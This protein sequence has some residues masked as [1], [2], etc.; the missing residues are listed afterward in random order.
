MKELDLEFRGT[1]EVSNFTFRQIAPSI[2]A[3]VYEIRAAN[4]ERH[5]ETFERK[6]QLKSDAVIAGKCISFDEQVIYPK[7]SS[8]GDWAWCFK[9]KESA[10]RRFE[11]FKKDKLVTAEC[12]LGFNLV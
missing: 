8:F 1:G 10:M 5:Y 3:Y 2:Y 6:E 9:V 4:N 11:E 12:S 7:S